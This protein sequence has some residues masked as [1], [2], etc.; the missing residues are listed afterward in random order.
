MVIHPVKLIKSD[1]SDAARR[2]D[3][4]CI[5]TPEYNRVESVSKVAVHSSLNR[6]LKQ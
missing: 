3:D 1:C 6:P 2:L 5:S 4:N